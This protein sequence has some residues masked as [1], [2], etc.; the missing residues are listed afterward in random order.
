[1]SPPTS[2]FLL[3]LR[4]RHLRSQSTSTLHTPWVEVG[5]SHLSPAPNHSTTFLPSM[6]EYYDQ[7]KPSEDSQRRPSRTF[8][9]VTSESSTLT[10]FGMFKKKS[11]DSER[12]ATY[13]SEEGGRTK[14][15]VKT[16]KRRS[17]QLLKM[18]FGASGSG[19][20]SEDS[21]TAT[22]SNTDNPDVGSTET[23]KLVSNTSSSSRSSKAVTKWMSQ[24][25][26]I[27]QINPPRTPPSPQLSTPSLTPS[28]FQPSIPLPTF[29]NAPTLSHNVYA[30]RHHMSSPSKSTPSH[31]IVQS[32]DSENTPTSDMTYPALRS[33]SSHLSPRQG[34]IP[35]G[36]RNTPLSVLNTNVSP[37]SSTSVNI[38]KYRSTRRIL[39][40]E[41]LINDPLPPPNGEPSR[42]ALPLNTSQSILQQSTDG[43][44]T[45]DVVAP[46]AR[47]TNHREL[48]DT[49]AGDPVFEACSALEALW[50][51]GSDH[52]DASEEDLSIDV[53][54]YPLP[55]SLDSST[56]EP[57]PKTGPIEITI[58]RPTHRHTDSD[59]TASYAM[60]S[61]L[62][63]D[64]L[65]SLV[66][67]V[68]TTAYRIPLK[69]ERPKTRRKLSVDSPFVSLYRASNPAELGEGNEIEP[70]EA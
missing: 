23:P 3:S 53:D 15:K 68:T 33:S 62:S 61:A 1:M 39:K 24:L 50:E 57:P 44:D 17:M 21:T 48:T 43:T 46:S 35:D 41:T 52:G 65:A 20:V 6:H 19:K 64:T 25:P 59:A 45:E 28:T 69:F 7:P 34:V 40:Y 58:T 36:A 14:E 49:E 11:L 16:L 5:P 26:Q 30:P 31:H 18:S 67:E 66:E 13:S 22:G 10:K 42:Y 51:Y 32:S 60:G 9:R 4:R 54:E 56:T 63:N 27:S 2:D 8:L 12:D 47:A 38:T 55:P 29:P 70:H 37:P